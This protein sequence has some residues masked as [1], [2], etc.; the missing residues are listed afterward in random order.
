MYITNDDRDILGTSLTSF[1]V[2]IKS[3]N[4]N[5]ITKGVLLNIKNRSINNINSFFINKDAVKPIALDLASTLLINIALLKNFNSK[6]QIAFSRQFISQY[7]NLRVLASVNEG[8][9]SIILSLLLM[10]MHNQLGLR[11]SEIE[12]GI[13]EWLNA[14][15]LKGFYFHNTSFNMHFIDML[16]VLLCEGEFKNSI[17]R[18]L[19]NYYIK[20][21][22]VCRY[23]LMDIDKKIHIDG[24][25][26]VGEEYYHFLP[27]V[28]LDKRRSRFDMNAL[29]GS[30]RAFG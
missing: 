11:N 16:I 6:E 13:I 1:E 10:V 17:S 26:K 14:N 20:I 15:E 22:R 19:N 23:N 18:L 5:T 28:M 2:A 8:A 7:E 27:P 29:S 12:R 3:I 24:I 4:S 9:D 30:G 25:I 21:G